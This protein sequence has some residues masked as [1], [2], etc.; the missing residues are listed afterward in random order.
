MTCI[1]GLI[2]KKRVW[3]GVDSVGS[4]YSTKVCRTDRK[5][6]KCTGSEN[7]MIAYTTSF[8]MGQILMYTEGFFEEL[9]VIKNEVDH[10]YMVTKFVPKVQKAFEEGG[11]GST[12]NGEKIAGN[13]LVAFKDQLYS[14]AS[15]YQVGVNSIGYA[16]DGCGM[17]LA[18]GSLHTTSGTKMS[19]RERILAA[20]RAASEFSVGVGLLSILRIQGIAK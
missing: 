17:E 6:F 19:P 8:R 4:D 18:L 1:V 9:S 3:L 13:F 10:K 20:L 14:I 12:K 7:G 16:A 15:D 2:D 5:L 11:F